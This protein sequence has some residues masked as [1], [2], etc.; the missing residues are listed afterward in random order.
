M[1]ESTIR[2]GMPFNLDDL[3]HRRAI[4]DNRVEFK[5]TWNSFI[6]PAVVKTVC[7]FANDLL[8][9]NGGYVVLGVEE[10][11]EEIFNWNKWI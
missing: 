1:D 10:D 6:E 8:N 4:E 3:I 2:S 7:A 5:A 11:G 9:L